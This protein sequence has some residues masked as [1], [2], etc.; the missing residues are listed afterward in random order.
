MWSVCKST[1]IGLCTF[2]TR[3]F[4]THL[5]RK[6]YLLV[7]VG[8]VSFKGKVLFHDCY[9]NNNY[10]QKRDKTWKKKNQVRTWY[11][12]L[13]F[14]FCTVIWFE[15]LI[16]VILFEV[17]CFQDGLYRTKTNWYPQEISL[18]WCSILLRMILQWPLF[19][20]FQAMG[21]R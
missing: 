12:S 2:L 3:L 17:P 11:G 4:I 9:Q 5:D 14:S 20:S 10:K 8:K 13:Q 7:S 15:K 18:Q 16:L 21:I 6:F 1:T 19:T